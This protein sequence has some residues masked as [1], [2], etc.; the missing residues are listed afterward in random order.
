M[1]T[2][3]THVYSIFH[4]VC[5]LTSP[6]DIFELPDLN[7]STHINHYLCWH[8]SNIIYA[9]L[10][11]P[12]VQ[13]ECFIWVCWLASPMCNVCWLASPMD[14]FELPDLSMSTYIK[15]Y[16][17]VSWHTSLMCTMKTLCSS[18][19]PKCILYFMNYADLHHPVIYWNCLIQ[20]CQHYLL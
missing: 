8:I 6:M 12:S 11:H 20:A 7:M 10:H 2:C 16:P 5:W 17:E 4:E 1:L 9:D 14:I 19:S 13:L 3:I 15:H 18:T